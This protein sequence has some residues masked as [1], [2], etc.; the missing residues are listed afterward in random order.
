M[1]TKNKWDTPKMPSTVDIAFPAN[2]IGTYLPEWKDIPETF[3][4]DWVYE[5]HCKKAQD[6]FFSGGTID[7]K[8]GI[9]EQAATKHFRTVLGSYEPKHEHKIAGAGYLLS[10]WA[11]V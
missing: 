2:V 3:R 6:I 5:K 8:K 4:E 11:N 1:K 7:W 10:L 9:D